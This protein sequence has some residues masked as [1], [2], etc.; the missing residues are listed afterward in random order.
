MQSLA[1]SYDEKDYKEVLHAF[2]LKRRILELEELIDSEKMAA[3]ASE[4]EA[5]ILKA[6][7]Y[8]LQK[9]H[10]RQLSGAQSPDVKLPSLSHKHSLSLPRPD[11]S[12]TSNSSPIRAKRRS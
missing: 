2:K 9:G 11:V 5:K 4:Q 3:D 7:I 6:R 10:S 12:K 1:W 8:K